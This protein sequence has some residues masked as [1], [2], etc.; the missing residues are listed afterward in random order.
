M[1]LIK[2]AEILSDHCR[3]QF[4][5]SVLFASDSDSG[6][7]SEISNKVNLTWLGRA[8][9]VNGLSEP[10]FPTSIENKCDGGKLTTSF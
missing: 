5:I 1:L 2:A 3:R 6:Q 8:K 7:A 9:H 4:K 10:N